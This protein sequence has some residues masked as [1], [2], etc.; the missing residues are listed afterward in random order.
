M[1][2]LFANYTGVHSVFWKDR[3]LLIRHDSLGRNATPEFCPLIVLLKD[4]PENVF[5]ELGGAL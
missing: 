3:K 5:V 2:L 1:K 4:A